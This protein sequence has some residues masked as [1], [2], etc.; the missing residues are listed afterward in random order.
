MITTISTALAQNPSWGAWL[1]S[2]VFHDSTQTLYDNINYE[3]PPRSDNSIQVA[4]KAWRMG[5]QNLFMDPDPW[6]SNLLCSGV[7]PAEE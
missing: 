7:V 3:I 1:P 5:K 6:P 4:I 2:C